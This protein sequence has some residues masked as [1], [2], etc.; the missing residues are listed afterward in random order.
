MILRVRMHD[1]QTSRTIYIGLQIA[2]GQIFE[3]VRAI[4]LFFK[5]IGNIKY[6]WWE[7][8]DRYF[9]YDRITWKT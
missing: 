5:T 7:G 9:F 8:R 6:G 3:I 1:G 4:N 2:T